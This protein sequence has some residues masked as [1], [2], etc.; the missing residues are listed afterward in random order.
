ML[1]NNANI[2]DLV[3]MF[4]KI[5]NK[6]EVHFCFAYKDGINFDTNEFSYEGS[7]VPN[8][9]YFTT[10][11][12]LYMFMNFGVHV[13]EITLPENEP[14]F[15]MVQDPD[16]NSEWRANQIIL[17]KKYTMEEFTRLYHEKLD[18]NWWTALS[19]RTDLSDDFLREFNDKI[20][21]TMFSL[22]NLDRTIIKEF[23]DKVD[24]KHLCCNALSERFIEDYKCRVVWFLVSKYSNLSQE[25]ISRF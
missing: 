13:R 17:G 24:W 19:Y 23:Q 25:F 9:L 16:K 10:I 6:D 22:H 18:K 20:D 8:G 11:E 5:T 3:A 21:W 2:K 15:K 1:K 4:Y 7:C 12:H 14:D